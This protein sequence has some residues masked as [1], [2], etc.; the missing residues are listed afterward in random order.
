MYRMFMMHIAGFWAP[1]MTMVKMKGDQKCAINLLT[2]QRGENTR[3]NPPCIVR[4][5]CADLERQPPRAARC[6]Q[7]E[8]R[9]MNAK[10]DQK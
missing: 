7:S 2:L 1:C 10:N 9:K 8:M 3:L 6:A 5:R 4:A